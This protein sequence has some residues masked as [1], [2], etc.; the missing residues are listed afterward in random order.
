M[1]FA[2]EDVRCHT[3]VH[4]S[5]AFRT[6]GHFGKATLLPSLAVGCTEW[7]R[8][9]LP[10]NSFSQGLACLFPWVERGSG[11]P[12]PPS[13]GAAVPGPGT[14]PAASR[15]PSP[16]FG[17][18]LGQGSPG[19]GWMTSQLCLQPLGGLCFCLSQGPSPA[20]RQRAHCP[21]IPEAH[22]AWPVPAVGKGFSTKRPRVSCIRGRLL[23]PPE[24]GTPGGGG[25]LPAFP[26]LLDRSGNSLKAI[27]FHM[28]QGGKS[29]RWL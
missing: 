23:V 8:K 24:A 21:S 3:I 26:F 25:A 18:C 15:T 6:P 5:S 17:S 19:L 4:S 28:R 10:A 27:W 16:A 7:G 2:L 12:G 14:S 22:I 9:H 1:R 11:V 29:C 20:A 13:A